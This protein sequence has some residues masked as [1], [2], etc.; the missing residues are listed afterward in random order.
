MKFL[1]LLTLF[2]SCQQSPVVEDLGAELEPIR[3]RNHQTG[4]KEAESCAACHKD[5]YK[6]WQQ[7]IHANSSY[8]KDPIHQAVV[9]AYQKFKKKKGKPVDYHCA[10]CH[11][12]MADN[13]MALMTGDAQLDPNNPTH[14]EGVSCRSCHSVIDVNKHPNFD[15]PVYSSETIIYGKGISKKRS[16]HPVRKWPMGDAS[17]VCLS[18]HAHKHNGKGTGICV[19]TGEGGEYTEGN[20][21]SCHMPKVAA[22]SQRKRKSPKKRH[23]SHLFAGSRNRNILVKAIHLEMGETS[24]SYTVTLKNNVAHAFPSS[25]PMRQAAVFVTGLDKGGRV[26]WSNKKEIN[27]KNKS[28]MMVALASKDGKFPVPPWMAASRKFDTRLKSG[29][30]RTLMFAKNK[31]PKE[32][33]T[34]KVEIKYRLLAPKMAKNFGIDLKHAKWQQVASQELKL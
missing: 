11:T 9:K 13:R 1:F 21:I 24:K 5:I 16:V 3:D 34:I 15:R 28:L 30:I 27:P 25:Q 2:V 22:P 20:C 31:F 12:P 7:S 19:M 33:A 26:T 17:K 29:E 8:Y 14:K 18:C 6:E 10:S 32:T 23:A 4:L